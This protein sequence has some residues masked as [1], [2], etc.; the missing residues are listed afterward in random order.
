MEFLNGGV[1]IDESTGLQTVYL[2]FKENSA[3]PSPDGTIEISEEFQTFDVCASKFLSV[4]YNPK[5]EKPEA[6]TLPDSTSVLIR[7]KP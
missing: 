4:I 5:Q 2:M 1:A 3:N 6:I 7:T